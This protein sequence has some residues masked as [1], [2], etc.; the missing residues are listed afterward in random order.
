MAAGKRADAL[1]HLVL[2]VREDQVAAAAVD[3]ERLAEI[4]PRHRAALDVPAWPAAPQGLSQPG[5]SGVDGFHST[6]SPGSRLYGATSIRAP[7]S[8]S[9]GLCPDR[10][11]YAWKLGTENST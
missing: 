9:S 5:R 2:M 11:P 3:V 7:A 1:R 4:A 8:S 6:K 10:C